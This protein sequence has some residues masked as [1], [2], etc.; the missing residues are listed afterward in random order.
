[1]VK[2]LPGEK[3]KE[4]KFDFDFTNNITLKVSNFGRLQTSNRYANGKLLN[5]SSINGYRIIRLKLFKPRLPKTQAAITQLQKQVFTLSKEIKILVKQEGNK[6]LIEE[7]NILLKAVKKSLQ[8]IYKEDLKYRTINYHSL[9]HRLVATCF[10]PVHKAEQTIV[11]HLDYDKLNNHISNLKW[12]TPEENL[13]H[14][15]K[16]PHVVYEKQQRKMGNSANAKNT[17][18]TVTKVMLLKKLL[19]NNKPVK[20]LTKQFKVTDMQIYR[21]KRGENWAHVPAAE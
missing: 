12:M 13:K 18:L 9:I 15:Q 3:W 17:K 4:V 6:K 16:S 1:M 5:G 14:Q 2:D 11:A 21:I 19:N 10:L 7:K 8:K 20:Q